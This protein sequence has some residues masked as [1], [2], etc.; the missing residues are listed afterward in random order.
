MSTEK[1]EHNFSKASPRDAL[2]FGSSRPGF[3]SKEVTREEVAAWSAFMKQKG[4]KRVLSLLGDDEK[5]Y[6]KDVDID[7][8]MVEEFGEG[9]YTRTSVFTPDSREIMSGAMKTARQAGD[10][11]VIHCSGG[12]GRA[13]LGIGV[14]L[15]DGYGLAPDEAA[16]EVAEETGKHVG[17]AR[18][19]NV[20]KLGHLVLHGS[21]DGFKK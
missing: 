1:P 3:P 11:I 13:G 15:V 20:G 7:V 5:C 18:K 9:N 8:A 6:Y 17:V 16:R 2:A 10:A 12:E 21:M 14:W 4:I 19:V